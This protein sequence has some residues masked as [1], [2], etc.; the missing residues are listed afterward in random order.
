MT[1]SISWRMNIQHDWSCILWSLLLPLYLTT[2]L[3]LEMC[4]RIYKHSLLVTSSP[5]CESYLQVKFDCHPYHFNLILSFIYVQSSYLN[6]IKSIS[7]SWKRINISQDRKS[8]F[9]ISSLKQKSH[10]ASWSWHQIEH[11]LL[12]VQRCQH[13]IVLMQ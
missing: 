9:F 6:A 2:Q 4:N 11:V 3:P 12:E 13:H 10:C 1:G 8:S 5:S 7:M